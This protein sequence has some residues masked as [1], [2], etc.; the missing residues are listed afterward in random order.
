MIR[1]LYDNYDMNLYNETAVMYQNVIRKFNELNNVFGFQDLFSLNASFLFALKGGYFSFK[2][3]MVY[4]APF[5][6]IFSL[7]G[8]DIIAGHG[9]CRHISCLLI[10]IFK[11]LSIEAYPLAVE[12]YRMTLL[13]RLYG[14]HMIVIAK[15]GDK[16]IVLDSVNNHYLMQK[17]SKVYNN[18]DIDWK[19]KLITTK[20]WIKKVQKENWRAFKRLLSSN[21]LNIMEDEAKYLE[22]KALDIC[23]KN[24]DMYTNFFLENYELYRD[25]ACK[26]RRIEKIKYE[27][28]K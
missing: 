21:I 27:N 28:V 18:S 9:V 23:F 17:R 19:I 14:N 24:R 16:K 13:D 1:L 12:A 15:D 2:G 11:D 20:F 6:D 22:Q 3:R 25:I 10:D 8:A 5:Y 4:D 7:Y 26:L